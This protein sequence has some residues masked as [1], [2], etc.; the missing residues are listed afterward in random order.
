[1]VCL[2]IKI[3]ANSGVSAV[4]WFLLLLDLMRGCPIFSDIPH[5]V[6]LE[7]DV[8][9]PGGLV[10]LVHARQLAGLFGVLGLAGAGG[11][12]DTH[13]VDPEVLNSLC[14]HQSLDFEQLLRPNHDVPGHSPDLAPVRRHGRS[15]SVREEVSV[16]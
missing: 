15:P 7:H 2:G 13:T 5:L 10:V 11:V 1:M 4:L 12:L 8:T 9:G 6:D 14:L 16:V 3:D